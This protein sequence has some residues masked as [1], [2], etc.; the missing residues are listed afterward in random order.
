MNQRHT[1]SHAVRP[2]RHAV[3]HPILLRAAIAAVLCGWASANATSP[4]AAVDGAASSAAVGPANAGADANAADTSFDRNLLSGAGTNTTDLARFEHGNPVLA[5]SYNIDVYLNA[6]WVGRSDVRFAAGSAQTSA[7]PCVD[8]QLL[9]QLGL[10][11][12]KLSAQLLSEL[13]DPAVCVNISS[14]IPGATMT[15]DMGE[16]RLDTSVPQA[17][18]EQT[19]RGY[20]SPEYWD[21]G[22]PAGL[23]NYNFNSYRSSSQGLSQTTAYLG[24]NAGFNFGPWHLHQDSTAIWQSAVPGTSA[25]LKWQNIDSYVQRDLPSLRA[26]LTIGDSYTDGRVFDSFGLRG[27]QLA[28]DDRMLP[29]S[30]RGYAP[31]VRG[32]ADSNAKVT[33]RQNG[34]QIYQTTVAPGPFT[35]N[36]L[37]PTGYGGNFDVTITEADGRSRTFSV[38]YASVAQLLRPGTTRFSVAAGQLRNLSLVHQPDV[39]QATVQHGFSNLFTGYA[40]IEGSQG[41]A[42]LLLG[43]AINTRYGA[44]AFDVTEAHARI[45]GFSTHSGQSM[46]LSYSK[47]LSETNTSLSVAAYRYSTSGYLSLNDAASARDYAARGIDTF[48]YVSPAPVTTIDGVPLQTVL[49]PAQQTALSGSGY[50]PVLST[51]GLQRQR[52]RFDLTLSQGL[53]QR[54]GSFYT[55][56]S[57]SDYWNRKGTDTQ[58]QLGYNNSFHR[59]SYGISATRTRDPLGRYDNEYFASISVPL[60][61]SAHAPTFTLNMTRDQN[62]NTQEQTMLSGSAGAD[63]QFNYGAS[64]THSSAGTGNSGSVNGGYRSPYAVFNASYG[65]GSGYSQ[66]SFNV[67]GAVVAHPGGI[68][69]GQPMGDTVGIVYVP[70]AE[71]ARL[72]NASGARID[73]SGYALVPYLTPYSLNTVGID[74]KG[75]PLDVQLDAT[76]AQVA[77][78]AGAVVMLKFKTKNG[79]TIIVRVRLQNGQ[80]LPFGTEV[81]NEQGISLGVAGQ[82]GQILLRGVDQAGQLTARWQDDSGAGMSCSFHYQ[83]APRSK[84]EHTKS[85]VEINATCTQPTVAVVNRSGA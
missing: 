18:L 8:G 34:V 48:R 68:T 61:D 60:G 77:P 59:V 26:Q 73:H 29:D 63:N 85:Y 83:L 17:Y 36:D 75:L 46:R 65:S 19:A 21:V 69:F 45:P 52:N 57:A 41:Y 24:L 62:S 14:L 2:R 72:T 31:V 37:Y 80:A 3:R 33:V 53:G 15:F 54:G 55:N 81:F 78:H 58:F 47:I 70:G 22:V 9:G 76:S 12:N 67:N 16:L 51:T 25:S 49:T 82:A 79:R 30:V 4:I 10:H 11:P 66:A 56:V 40:G 38:P 50:N 7:T 27:V 35:I 32:V 43:S 42:A 6:T 74:P 20:I 44:F 64:A 13:K 5:G 23:L 84:Y 28:T 39:V 1:T 71:G